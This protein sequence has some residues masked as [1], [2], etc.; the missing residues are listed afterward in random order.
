M[1]AP[2]ASTTTM[3][4]GSELKIVSI[5]ASTKTFNRTTSGLFYGPSAVLAAASFTIAFTALWRYD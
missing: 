1:S 5:D 3:P 2:P 4:R